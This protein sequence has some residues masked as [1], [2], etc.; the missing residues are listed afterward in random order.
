MMSVGGALGG[1]FCALVAPLIFDWTYEH[2]LLLAAAAWLMRTRS[3]FDRLVS[4]WDGSELARRLTAGGA[5]L[6]VILSLVGTG[7][8]DIPYSSEANRVAGL[9]V[10]TI[11]IVAI[12]NRA[13]F[14]CAVAALLMAAGGWQRV[15]SSSTPGKMTRSFFGIYS[16]RQG[17]NNSRL[18]VHG[19][20]VH[21]VQNLGSPERERMATTYYVPSSGVG[22]AMAAREQLFG[23]GARI[24]LVGLGT[25]TLAC[26][27]R[28][29]EQWTIYE[30]DPAVVG[31]A[32]DPKRFT[33][34]ARC[35]PG[36]PIKIGDARLL[37]ERE[38]PATA[39]LLVVDAFS[40]DAV[41]MHLLTREAFAD[42]RR[43][44][45]PSGLLL[46][47]ISNRYLDLMPVVA[48]AAADGNWQARLRSYRPDRA[49]MRLNEYGSDWIALSQSPATMDQLVR[50]GGG[51]WK[52]LPA[53]P[54]FRPWTDDHASVL[55]LIKL[56]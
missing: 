5:M 27:A 8:F 1:L 28:P 13:L 26:Y 46:V 7:F 19:T 17:P 3:P 12:G 56:K 14:A 23:A 36:A 42:Y 31:I 34:L 45:S 4:L 18:L 50:S 30:I 15:E 35:N 48:A 53:R 21:G 2:L 41:P 54:G 37:I 11:A 49:H 25:G 51:K 20:T 10:L 9:V 38:R 44:L 16:I 55:S 43:L 29:G 33:F 22:L 6:V 47:H 40:S 39:D 24:G 32:R 52:A